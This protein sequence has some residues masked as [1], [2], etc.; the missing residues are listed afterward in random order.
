VAI[1][2]QVGGIQGGTV[3]EQG[4]EAAGMAAGDRL[5]PAPEQAVV[6]QNEV[7]ARCRCALESRLAGVH[8]RRD[9]S[10]WPAALNL[11]PVQR[12]RVVRDSGDLKISIEVGNEVLLLNR[13]RYISRMRRGQYGSTVAKDILCHPN[14]AV[15]L[16]AFLHE[17]PPG[18]DA[19]VHD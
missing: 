16:T 3:K 18:D 10:D 4:P 9:P 17:D 6:D 13:Q 11:Q 5:E 2:R 14:L 8:R 19:A 15:H 7:G 12:P 1:Q